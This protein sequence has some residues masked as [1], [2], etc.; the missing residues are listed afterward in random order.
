MACDQGS[1]E[2]FSFKTAMKYQLNDM[3]AD[4][5]DCIA[6]VDSQLQACLDKTDW[7]ALLNNSDDETV[8]NDFRNKFFPCFKNEDGL[9]YFQ[10]KQDKS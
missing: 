8:M 3:C 6:V 7:R 1:I 5:D 4:D 10:V 9:P 2:E